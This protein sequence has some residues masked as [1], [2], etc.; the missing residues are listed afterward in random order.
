[1]SDLFTKASRI[2]TRTK[3]LTVSAVILLACGY[4]LRDEL[5]A[6]RHNA[7]R[8]SINQISPTPTPS[9][10]SSPY[11]AK[12]VSTPL[13]HEL[14]ETEELASPSPSAFDLPAPT[15]SVEI[16]DT[17][18]APLPSSTSGTPEPISAPPQSS[19]D[20]Q[21]VRRCMNGY[22]PCNR[23]LLTTA[24]RMEVEAAERK[25]NLSKC[26]NGYYPCDRDLLTTDELS[27]V[28]ANETKR[29]LSR[30][31]NGYYPCNRSLL[32]ADEGLQT[33][34]NE[35]RRNLSRCL[36]GYYPCNRSLLSSD[37]AA[38]VNRN[39][40]KRNLSRCLNGYHPCNRSL[41]TA[42]EAT[43]VDAGEARRNYSRC[44]NGYSP[45]DRT[46]LSPEQAAE[47]ERRR[48]N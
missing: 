20:P 28:D 31:L 35:I 1:M 18:Q 45:C 15:E 46:R 39:E 36:N 9:S 32:T 37:E 40:I 4:S 19:I 24:E 41:L 7:P 6:L 17:I 44:L 2:S 25:R 23:E 5:R 22:Y 33:D 38:Q 27:Q 3:F 29:N 14:Q 16:E 48:P 13:D 10:Q 8:E 11:I 30:C 43:Q 12:S 47:V 21:N 34:V 42:D 26:L